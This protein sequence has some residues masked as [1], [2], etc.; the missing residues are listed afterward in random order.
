MKEI[1]I[2]KREQK[3]KERT[4]CENVP[5]NSLNNNQHANSAVHHP[6]NNA[7]ENTGIQNNCGQSHLAV[8]NMSNNNLN[9]N[10]NQNFINLII[11]K[12][13]EVIKG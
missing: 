9:I 1:S 6:I 4:Q 13:Q 12:N 10:D 8:S 7:N 5:M 3:I 11:K 2:S